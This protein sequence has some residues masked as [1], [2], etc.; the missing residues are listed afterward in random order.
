MGRSKASDADRARWREL[1]RR[2]KYLRGLTPFERELLDA[3]CRRHSSLAVCDECTPLRGRDSTGFPSAVQA[4]GRGRYRVC[5]ACGKLQ[6]IGEWSFV[7]RSCHRC[8]GTEPEKG[9]TTAPIA[10]PAPSSR[11]WR[12]TRL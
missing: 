3:P 1:Q 9:E 11:G 2:E 4:A 12:I 6:Q 10:K 7:A 8:A 5:S